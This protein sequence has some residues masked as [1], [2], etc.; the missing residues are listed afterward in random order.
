MGANWFE[1][2]AGPGGAGPGGKAGASAGA[3]DPADR[4]LQYAL[5]GGVG[6]SKR[7]EWMLSKGVTHIL[8]TNRGDP[9]AHPDDFL[10]HVVNL[11][12]VPEEN[13]FDFTFG[14][15]LFCASAAA[16]KGGAVLVHCLMGISRSAS[17]LAAHLMLAREIGVGQALGII[18]DARPRIFPNAGFLAQ[19]DR[20][21][22]HVMQFRARRRGGGGEGAARGEEAAGTVQDH[23]RSHEGSATGTARTAT[24]ADT[25]LRGALGG[26]GAAAGNGEVAPQSSPSQRGPAVAPVARYSC[27][28]CRT[29]LFL[30]TDVVEQA[31]PALV[32]LPALPRGHANPEAAMQAST[33]VILK[34]PPS[35]CPAN[36]VAVGTDIRCPVARCGAKLGHFLKLS[37]AHANSCSSGSAALQLLGKGPVTAFHSK[38]LDRKPM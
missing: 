9:P 35:W 20:L 14:A 7:K 34:R 19:L 28:S 30:E 8:Q 17:L 23:Q 13:M 25:A 26:I 21:E 3:N 4:V 5:L 15:H 1:P 37:P 22:G 36:L 16:S 11:D 38:K 24:A 6:A 31:D 10:Y 27:R 33:L 32:E 2:R 29:D 18:R 12:D